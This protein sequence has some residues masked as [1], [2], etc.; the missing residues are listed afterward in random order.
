MATIAEN[1]QTIAT[2]TADIKDA[3]LEKGG[4]ITGDI[5]TYGDAIRGIGGAS[6]PIRN[7]NFFDFE[8]TVIKSFDTLSEMNTFG[9]DNIV[10]PQHEGLTFAGWNYS[11]DAAQEQI[12]KYGKIDI[13]A[14]YTIDAGEY[15]SATKFHITVAD[16]LDKTVECTLGVRNTIID[17]GD[18]SPL[19]E[20]VAGPL[21]HPMHVYS[22]H[23]DYVITIYNGQ[24]EYTGSTMTV[25]CIYGAGKLRKLYIGANLFI[26]SGLSLTTDK[27]LEE[28]VISTQVLR[29]S[30]NLFK[31]CTALKALVLPKN[32]RTA[33]IVEGCTAL[34]TLIFPYNSLPGD[35]VAN[36]CSRLDRVIISSISG[37]SVIAKESFAG[38]SISSFI[39]PTA[40]RA[41]DIYP[42]AFA[43]NP[44][45]R[46]IDCTAKTDSIVFLADVNAFEN[47]P[48]LKYIIVPDNLVNEYRTATNWSNYAD[49]I[50]MKAQYEDAKSQYLTL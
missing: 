11:V 6:E 36:G 46:E 43:D 50:I 48:N 28:V 19:Y 40:S 3:I 41:V 13:G 8:G 24:I 16:V 4:T 12:Q 22:N 37:N 26:V 34:G 7:I 21:W 35:N 10:P 25:G 33:S 49:K 39:V 44:R 18:G 17:W 9:W 45:L 20:Q 5:S 30:E 42:R 14:T 31:G 29:T 27:S 15:E 38:T 2:A 32:H 1:I 23:G 47:C